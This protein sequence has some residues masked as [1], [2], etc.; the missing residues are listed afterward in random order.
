ME[1]EHTTTRWLQRLSAL[2]E[3]MHREEP[4]KLVHH[5][6]EFRNSTL[7]RRPKNDD[8]LLNRREKSKEESKTL[9]EVKNLEA[10]KQKWTSWIFFLWGIVWSLRPQY[11]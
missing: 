10:E 7:V 9:L 1:T 6:R 8:K 5:S 3:R 4:H 11:P 2:K